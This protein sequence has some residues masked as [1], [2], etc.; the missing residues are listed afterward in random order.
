MRRRTLAAW[1]TALGVSLV[2]L[3]FAPNGWARAKTRVRW[4]DVAV[5]EGDD[6]KR[7]ARTFEKLL[8]YK[9]RRA[10]WGKGE[11]LELTA[12]VK[13]LDWEPRGDVLRVTVTVVAKIKGVRGA[14]SHIRI[15]GDPDKRRELEKRALKIVA[16]G[17]VTRLSAIAREQAAAAKRAKEREKA[18]ATEG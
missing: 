12:R 8:V 3:T 13:R 1:A 4:V 10:K 7:V 9:S 17:L 18:A 5:R 2:L 15:G 11:R 16:G 6:Q 14:R